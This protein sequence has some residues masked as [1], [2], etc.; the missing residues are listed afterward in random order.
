MLAGD[1][2]HFAPKLLALKD[3]TWRVSPTFYRSRTE[4]KFA[5][6]LH[7]ELTVVTGA[8]PETPRIHRAFPAQ[9][10]VIGRVVRQDIH[11]R[12]L[13]LFLLLS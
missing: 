3:L 10:G 1:I 11:R 12:Y 9:P 7:R 8:V 5:V 6:L 4:G 2:A 13:F